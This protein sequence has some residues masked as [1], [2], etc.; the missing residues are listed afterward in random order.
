M[1]T[2]VFSREM[3]IKNKRIKCDKTK[4]LT[5]VQPFAEKKVNKKSKKEAMCLIL[6]SN[7]EMETN[8]AVLA[9]IILI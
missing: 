6:A 7:H 2:K 9:D 1:C 4:I 5:R 3:Y 8:Q